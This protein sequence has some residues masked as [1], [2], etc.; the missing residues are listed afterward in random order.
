MNKGAIIKFG[1]SMKQIM[2]VSTKPLRTPPQ[3]G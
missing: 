1:V 2:D 3:R